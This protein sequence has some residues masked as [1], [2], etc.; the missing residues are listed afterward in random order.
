VIYGNVE[1]RQLI[2]NLPEGCCV[3]VPCLVDGNGLQPTAVGHLPPQCAALNR[4]NINVQQLAVEAVLTEEV[5]HIYHAA[6]L[7]PLTAAQLTLSQIRAMVDEMRVA[8]SAW[9]PPFAALS[10]VPAL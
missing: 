3:E 7:D 2:P 9:L 8:E 1:N 6:M 10:A 5:E 4:T